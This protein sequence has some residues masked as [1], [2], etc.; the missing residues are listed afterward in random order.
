VTLGYLDDTA[1]VSLGV[2]DIHVTYSNK[3]VIG[4]YESA[5][6]F[7]PILAMSHW[8]S[9]TLGPPDTRSAASGLTL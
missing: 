3:M 1:A 4:S 5:Y 9:K 2:S 7:G 8:A 6:C